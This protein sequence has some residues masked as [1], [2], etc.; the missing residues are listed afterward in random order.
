MASQPLRQKNS[1]EKPNKQNNFESVM[2]LQKLLNKQVKRKL[3]ELI[4]F[5][6]TSKQV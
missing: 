6:L 1:F 2:V 4:N 3:F 5:L